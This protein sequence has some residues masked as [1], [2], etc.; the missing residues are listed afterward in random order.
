MDQSLIDKA[1]QAY[2]QSQQVAANQQQ[3]QSSAQSQYDT[4]KNTANT[5]QNQLSDFSK[6][7]QSGTDIYGK[8]LTLANQNAGYN[9]NNLNQAQQQV[10]QLTGIMGGLPRAIQAN[11]ANYGA[12]AGN[13]A[14]QYAT[15]TGNLNQS[16]GLA[17]QNSAN[18]IAL[19]QA[20]LTGA[21][22]ATSAGVQT[23]AQQLQG[24]TAAANNAQQVMATSQTQLQSINEIVQQQ[25]YITAQQQQA[26]ALA[27]QS[28]ATAK[29]ALAQ[30]ATYQAQAQLY[31][32]QAGNTNYTTQAQQAA[33]A[34]TTAKNAAAS[35]AN[36][37]GSLGTGASLQGGVSNS[38]LQ[39]NGLSLQ[40]GR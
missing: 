21:Q 35:K 39:G 15:T 24:L 27:Q 20:G 12:T 11:N 18:Q 1:N 13:V 6:N 14:N 10:A 29:N 5:A 4:S 23:Q 40:G 25:G 37:V 16:L 38:L 9:V 26:Y 8:Q 7:M 32:A 36:T 33:D 31:T 30:I 2:Q 19:Q 22:N 28:M 34:A 17:N 3:Q